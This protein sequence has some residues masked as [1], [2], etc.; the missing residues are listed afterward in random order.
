MVKGLSQRKHQIIKDRKNAI[1]HA[2]NIMDEKSIL[3]ILG[4]GRE[5]YE[6]INGIKKEHND[7]N[8]VKGLLNEN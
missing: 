3:L 1:S 5:N 8:I 4:K 2:I 6:I 7:I